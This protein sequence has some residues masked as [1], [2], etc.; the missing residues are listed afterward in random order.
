MKVPS[1]GDSISEGTIQTYFK[2]KKF[3]YKNNNKNRGW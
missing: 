2:S 3:Q 1:L